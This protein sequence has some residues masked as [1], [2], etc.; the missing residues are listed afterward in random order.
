MISIIIII[1]TIKNNN[2]IYIQQVRKNNV[3][4]T[5]IK[6]TFMERFRTVP[7]DHL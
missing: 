7:L 1:I 3:I 2:N 6:L 5:H 4:E